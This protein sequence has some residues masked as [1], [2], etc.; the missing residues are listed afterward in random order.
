MH[1]HH[2]TFF[3]RQLLFQSPK[4]QSPKDCLGPQLLLLMLRAFAI[5]YIAVDG[6]IF[7]M[8]DG[9]GNERKLKG[10]GKK[11]KIRR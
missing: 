6:G 10:K 1:I 5:N 2:K 8:L 11:P 3:E 7:D 4:V 9:G